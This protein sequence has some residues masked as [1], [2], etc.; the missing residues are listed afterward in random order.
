MVRTFTLNISLLE[1]VLP[2]YVGWG[3]V[4]SNILQ[5]TYGALEYDIMFE[6]S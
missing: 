1:K 4:I 2:L 6:T 3:S 5:K